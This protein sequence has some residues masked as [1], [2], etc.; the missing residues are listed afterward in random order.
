[1]FQSWI[2]VLISALFL[3]ACGANGGFGV[4]TKASFASNAPSG[5][6]DDNGSSGPTP[7]PGSDETGELGICSELALLGVTW[8]STLS[9]DQRRSMALGLN[10]SGSFEGHDGWANLTNNFDG[11]GVSFGLLNQNLGSGSLQPLWLK[12]RDR[13]GANF[14]ALFTSAHYSSLLS[15]LKAWESANKSN[16]VASSLQDSL[17]ADG[18]LSILDEE[19][20]KEGDGFSKFL[21]EEKSLSALSNEDESV[22]WAVETLYTD[23]AG[24]NFQST[25]KTE[26]L[27]LGAHPDYVSVQIEAALKIHTKALNYMATL[28]LTERRAYLLMF[29]FVVQ[30]GG[31]YAADINDYENYFGSSIP[32]ETTRLKK[33]LELRLRHVKS[34][35][36][37]DVNAR[38]SAIINGNGTV[39]GSKRNFESEYCFDGSVK[40]TK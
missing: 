9:L 29:D 26:L 37:D 14:K 23:S 7:V 33:I 2:L 6:D 38:K 5:T 30:N 12:M 16:L 28:K 22:D 18:R 3:T 40:V 1:M 39:H 32:S 10:I 13:Y 35:Y 4:A 25:W 27:K 15:M 36:K 31:L 17:L 21:I 19:G 24:K 11:M 8:P 34:E 20:E